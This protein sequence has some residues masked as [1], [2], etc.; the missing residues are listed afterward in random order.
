MTKA[1]MKVVSLL[2]IALGLV[3]PLSAQSSDDVDG[4]RKQLHDVQ[5][6][7]K[8]L[9]KKR[10]SE[11]VE[12]EQIEYLEQGIDQLSEK[13]GNRAVVHAFDG[14]KLDIGGFLHTAYTYIEGD[15]HSEGSFNRQNFELLIGTE[16]TEKWSTFI[17]GG[18]LREANDPFTVGSRTSPEFDTNDRNPLIIGWANYASGD[19]FNVRIGRM[20]TPHGVINI[21]HFPATLLDPEQPQLLRPFGGNT[22]FPNFS[23]GVQ[24][25]GKKF[26]GTGVFS[27]AT[28]YANAT[29]RMNA[30]SND[31]PIWGGRVAYGN[32]SG[33]W[34]IG[35]NYSSSYRASTDA[36]NTMEGVDFHVRTTHFELKS[37]YYT[38]DEDRF[39]GG[40]EGNG[41][42]E[43]Y[44]VQPIVHFNP[45]WSAFYR[46]DFLDSGAR[47]GES[48]EN[49]IGLNF[50]PN[51]N[52]RLRLTLT[53]KEFEGGANDDGLI[54]LI[55][56]AEATIMQVSGT[57]SF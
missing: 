6:R 42:R 19:L 28:Y 36:E 57:F 4:L 21:E 31:E 41:D 45:H 44:Y 18:F 23:T 35:V 1:L 55:D 13:V 16:L 20:I 46:Y 8:N 29:S 22:I 3:I 49:V 47:V 11:S 32:A 50:L 43:A 25:H 56:D 24:L 9:E 51:N 26:G 39:Y 17:A 48:T 34:E 30:N 7:L 40:I 38:T 52:V 27:Y 37:E 5:Q 2:T 12:S 15:D 54:S 53:D 10:A 33:V 14:M